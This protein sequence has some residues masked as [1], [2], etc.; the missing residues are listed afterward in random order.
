VRGTTPGLIKA[1]P[2]VEDGR[3]LSLRGTPR[4]VRE[5]VVALVVEHQSDLRACEI[6]D[7]VA[8]IRRSTQTK[9]P[10]KSSQL[11]QPTYAATRSWLQ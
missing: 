6:V 1:P 3:R 9:L 4:E 10:T 2:S 11:Q 5:R 7:L 8:D